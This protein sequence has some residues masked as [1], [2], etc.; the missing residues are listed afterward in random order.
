MV[1]RLQWGIG[2]FRDVFTEP[3]CQ[4]VGRGIGRFK[5]MYS[6]RIILQPKMDTRPEWGIGRFRDVQR[7]ILKPV[8]MVAKL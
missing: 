5:V 8:A 6:Y 2:R 3:Y 1:A 7:T 4:T